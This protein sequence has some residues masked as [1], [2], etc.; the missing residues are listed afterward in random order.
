MMIDVRFNEIFGKNLRE[1]RESLELP[2]HIFAGRYGG[3][4]STLQ[5][6]VCAPKLS[7]LQLSSQSC[8]VL[9]S[10]GTIRQKVCWETREM[11]CIFQE[12]V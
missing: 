12:T 9:S 6:V 3:A 5:S 7:Y 1:Y 11:Y 2:R 8:P 4:A 10:K